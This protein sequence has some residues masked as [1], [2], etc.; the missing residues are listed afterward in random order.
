[1]KIAIYSC[2]EDAEP[3]EQDCTWEELV[4]LLSNHARRP[5][6]DGGLWSPVRIEGLRDS[7]NVRAITFAVFDVDHRTR[8]EVT[9]LAERLAGT[10]HLAYTTFSH[11]SGGPDDLCLRLVMPLSREVLPSEWPAVRQAIVD[12]FGITSPDLR[13][14]RDLARMYYL[15]AAPEGAEA[16]TE[17][18]RGEVL[19]VDSL[20][21]ESARAQ[22]GLA[23]DR[24]DRP[25]RE[26]GNQGADD[27]T[28]AADGDAGAEPARPFDLHEARTR[29]RR[30]RKPESA[31]LV[32]RI[33]EGQPLAPKGDRDNTVNALASILAFVLPE[34]PPEGALEL[35]RASINLMPN[36]DG[37]DWCGKFLD[38]F[39]RAQERKRDEQAKSERLNALVRAKGAALKPPEADEAEPAEAIDDTWKQQLLVKV[40]SD[41]SQTIKS[42]PTNVYLILKH[43]PEWRGVIRWNEVT[44]RIEVVGGP[45]PKVH[46]DVFDVA[47]SNWLALSHWQ[48][49]V[50]HRKVG[51]QVAAVARENA[52]DPLKDW[53]EGLQWDGTPRAE[54]LFV[55]Y[56][57]AETTNG[58]GEDI[59][60]HLAL[61][62]RKWLISAVARAL[63]PGCKVD[64][65][66]ILEG[67]Q[68][69]KK[70][71]AYDIL[72]GQWFADT[73]VSIG[74]KDGAMV[75]SARW[76][77]E[78]AELDSFRR[79]ESETL[80]AFLSRRVDYYRPPYGR[81]LEECPRRAVFVGTTNKDTYLSDP[82]GNRRY[83]PVTVTRIEADKLKQDREQI[84]AE[85]VAAYKAGERWHFEGDEVKRAEALAQ[86][87][88]EPVTHVEAVLEWW[89]ALPPARRPSEVT[90][91]TVAREA[92]KLEDA[93]IDRATETQ[94]GTALSHLGFK[95]KRPLRDGV[96]LRVYA[97]P[98]HMKGMPQTLRT[99]VSPTLQEKLKGV[100]S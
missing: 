98:E 64:T 69:L 20:V 73:S 47:V 71:M 72:G 82:T 63:Q 94:I 22:H 87:R 51:P 39:E 99:H 40:D 58:D 1:V 61:L 25:V 28:A 70:S 96:R 100:A 36:P 2:A 31:E 81:S 76:I 80:K 65:I 59:S 88:A 17:H 83:W 93:R 35:C 84:W 30:I 38:S 50:D 77:V 41:G 10:E 37:V 92:L 78:L 60:D 89:K 26:S 24:G 4:E 85:A 79:A 86:E 52:Y 46:P 3:L 57:G 95:K 29:L 91:R 15:P 54:R 45:L 75:A 13:K 8:D 5:E 62:G 44:H 11:L 14:T 68:G 97:A 19:D 21:L 67:E 49:A 66:L 55:D 16:W 9:A 43:S 23:H 34:A 48:L 27:A 42:N 56:L 32:R 6:K 90:S 53:L 74:D 33:L 7:D 12:M 18:N